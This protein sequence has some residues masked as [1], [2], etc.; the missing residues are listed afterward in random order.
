MGHR[1]SRQEESL[2]LGLG[3]SLAVLAVFYECAK[4]VVHKRLVAFSS[5]FEPFQDIVVDA[6]IDMVLGCRN[7]RDGLGPVG[8]LMDVVGIG[9]Y[10]CLQL[11]GGYRIGSSPIRS[12]LTSR[13]LR[14]D[15][16]RRIAH[17]T[18]FLPHL[19]LSLL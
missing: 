11:L 4:D 15:L 18:A 6:D 12:V 3:C 17:G 1:E 7:A 19:S 2:T 5:R 9:P 10:G 16:F 13:D 8:F 14:F